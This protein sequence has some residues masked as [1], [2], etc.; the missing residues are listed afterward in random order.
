[1][2]RLLRTFLF[3]SLGV[4]VVGVTSGVAHFP[5]DI[6]VVDFCAEGGTGAVIS[7][8]AATGNQTLVS[9]NQ[10]FRDPFDI[11]IDGTGRVFVADGTAAA[12]IEVDPHPPIAA[13][14]SVVA[15]GAPFVS[16]IGVAVGIGDDLWVCDA[17][18]A[19]VFTVNKNSGV[20]NLVTAGGNLVAPFGVA[21]NKFAQ[22]YVA[23][24]LANAVIEVTGGVQTVIS[25]GQSFLQPYGITVDQGAPF[26]PANEPGGVYVADRNI[27]GVVLVDVNLP[28]GGNQT[29]VTQGQNLSGAS[30]LA[31]GGWLGLLPLPFYA[32]D[33]V[34]RIVIDYDPTGD[35]LANQN[36]I[37]A[38]QFFCGPV[39]LTVVPEQP[40][41]VENESWGGIKGLYR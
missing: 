5:G 25:S 22:V 15:S 36:V 23:D 17:G 29:I 11:A 1:M 31:I 9:V 6:L 41:Q 20:V 13:N 16:P 28:D 10:N 35:P 37:S 4:A 30:G 21:L 19:A 12:I 34:S 38:G 14:Q 27:S 7:V 24:R 40:V 33:F 39:R 2:K 26:F 8:D 18:A 3:V 32:A